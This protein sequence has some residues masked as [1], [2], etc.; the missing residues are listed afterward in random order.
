MDCILEAPR[1]DNL[2][3]TESMMNLARTEDKKL[4]GLVDS[5]MQHSIVPALLLSSLFSS[6]S[7]LEIRR[8]GA[9]L[10]FISSDGY[11]NFVSLHMGHLGSFD[12]AVGY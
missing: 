10:L 11:M 9:L 1:H 2:T 4:L 5:K 12:S 7:V 3:P 6:T 8:Y